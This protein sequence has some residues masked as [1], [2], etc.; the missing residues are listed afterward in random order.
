MQACGAP[1]ILAPNNH[2]SSP[3]HFQFS[4]GN[5]PTD[6]TTL[7]SHL[8]GDSAVLGFYDARGAVSES[9]GTAKS[10]SDARGTTGFGPTLTSDTIPGRPAWDSAHGKLSFLY[11]GS[12][13]VPQTLASAA[14]SLFSLSNKLSFVYVGISPTTTGWGRG[15]AEIASDGG[16]PPARELGIGT[17]AN[18]DVTVI[19]GKSQSTVIDTKVTANDS[20]VRVIIATA[21][22][23]TYTGQ[24]A[25]SSV[26]SNKSSP[27]GSGNNVLTVGASWQGRR[28]ATAVNPGTSTAYAVIIVNHILSHAE[29][30]TVTSWAVANRSATRVGP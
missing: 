22:D 11:K 9:A 30:S 6:I 10:W 8:G 24:V 12:S 15:A 16:D 21:N 17:F 3:L 4:A 19:A 20:L 13:Y 26:V 7:I 27:A 29:D 28:T 25:D 18:A 5:P 2:P 23:S 14:S 1:D